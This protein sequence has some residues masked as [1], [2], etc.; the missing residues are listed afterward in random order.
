MKIFSN[1]FLIIFLSTKAYNKFCFIFI[2]AT[3]INRNMLFKNVDE[4][5][6]FNTYNNEIK[7]NINN[8][9]RK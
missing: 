5:I 6:E 3:I 7:N 4:F 8:N 9:I 1:S 2:Q